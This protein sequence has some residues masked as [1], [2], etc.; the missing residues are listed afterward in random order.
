LYKLPN[1]RTKHVTFSVKNDIIN[2]LFSELLD[3]PEDIQKVENVNQYMEETRY[4]GG[5]VDPTVDMVLRS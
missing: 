4:R 2:V 1:E 5:K 3:S